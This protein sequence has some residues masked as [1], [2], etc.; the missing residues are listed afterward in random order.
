MTSLAQFSADLADLVARAAP[1]V[2]GVEQHRGQASG[3]VLSA[4][5][6]V[7]TNAHVVHA[8]R[9]PRIRL[10]GSEVV[11]AEIVGVDPRTDL[12]VL[13]AE[14]RDLAPLTLRPDRPPGV[15]HL[16]VAIGN[17]LGFE[18][19]V[20]VGVVSALYRD[21]PSRS[22]VLEGLIQT[23]AAINP[24]NSGGP[25]VGADGNLV[26][27]STAM[28]AFARGIGFAVPAHTASWV[29]SVIIQRGEVRRPLLGI[30]ARAE[31]LDK[32]TAALAGQDRAV[33]VMGVERRTPAESGGL[34]QGDLLLT[35]NGGT[36]WS[37]DDLSR[38]MVLAGDAEI[39]LGVLRG[40]E[41]RELSMRPMSRAWAA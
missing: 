16:V 11:K 13:R 18:R 27:V 4:D 25:L 32:K 17:P 28:I 22:G 14:A 6:Y 29:A 21:L 19:S 26:G 35:G 1:G 36:L 12:A 10:S 38:I 23:D 7:L 40:E 41:K 2:V 24:G 37:L 30:G 39:R 20:S 33:R 31:E 5:G 34:T 8:M 3:V 9:Q 15:G